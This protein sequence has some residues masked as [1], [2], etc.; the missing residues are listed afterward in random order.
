VVT[1]VSATALLTTLGNE[2]KKEYIE[3]D[4]QGRPWKYYQAAVHVRDGEPCLITQ[5]EYPNLTST[6]IIKSKEYVGAWDYA[7]FEI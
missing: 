7:T 3:L 2:L 4:G 5:V 1:E 6:T